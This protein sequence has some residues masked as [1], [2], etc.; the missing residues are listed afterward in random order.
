MFVGELIK[1]NP[2]HFLKGL[3]SIV[4]E[5]KGLVQNYIATER[6]MYFKEFTQGYDLINV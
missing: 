1:I 6:S 4:F 2:L 3:H 5:R